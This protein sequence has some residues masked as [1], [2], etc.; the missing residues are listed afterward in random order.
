MNNNFLDK[1]FEWHFVNSVLFWLIK[2]QYKCAFGDAKQMFRHWKPIWNSNDRKWE[3]GFGVGGYIFGLY[4][5]IWICVGGWMNGWIDVCVF[6][7]YECKLEWETKPPWCRILV[8]LLILCWLMNVAH[9][10]SV[11]PAK[12]AFKRAREHEVN[13]KMK[14]RWDEMR[15]RLASTVYTEEAH[16]FVVYTLSSF[17]KCRCR[18]LKSAAHL[19]LVQ[20]Y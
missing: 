20:I 18:P 12:H 10:T 3:R 7:E 19:A 17:S 16:P 5:N 2:S 4:A 11:V 9:W 8:L 1:T 13:M 15:W 14:M 6:V